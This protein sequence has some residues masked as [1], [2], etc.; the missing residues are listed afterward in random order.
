MHMKYKQKNYL[1][2][3]L[4]FF[5]CKIAN[6]KTQIKGY[7]TFICF[8]PQ[9]TTLFGWYGS[10]EISKICREIERSS[11]SSAITKTL[12]RVSVPVQEQ[13]EVLA[14]NQSWRSALMATHLQPKQTSCQP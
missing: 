13:T 2:Q 8:T 14:E 12:T 11:E 10:Q 5:S 4:K 9:L 3:H 1:N 6:L 7:G